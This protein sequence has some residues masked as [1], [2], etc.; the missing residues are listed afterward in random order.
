LLGGLGYVFFKT[1][2][3]VVRLTPMAKRKPTFRVG[4]TCGEDWGAMERKAGRQRRCG[5]CA[6]NVV[7][8]T[9]L[10]RSQAEVAVLRARGPEGSAC[11]R[12]AHDADGEP[13]FAPELVKPRRGATGVV[14][15]AALGLGVAGCSRSEPDPYIPAA[16]LAP[17]GPPAIPA[18]PCAPPVL[19]PVPTT[20]AMTTTSASTPIVEGPARANLK[21][22]RLRR[23]P[24]HAPRIPPMPPMNHVWMGMEG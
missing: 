4:K 18:H 12:V 11:I 7:D 8:L 9:G 19:T 22:R 1:T 2:A 20:P 16:S 5:A 15:A 17:L 14:L 24:Q 10:T 13:L 21:D 6:R 23:P 3:E